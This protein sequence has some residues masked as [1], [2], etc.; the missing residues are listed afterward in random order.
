MRG[1]SIFDLVIAEIRA[2]GVTML[3]GNAVVL[4][5]RGMP[6]C[7]GKGLYFEIAEICKIAHE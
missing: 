5:E 6:T 7:C 4:I 3:R 2:S 1:R